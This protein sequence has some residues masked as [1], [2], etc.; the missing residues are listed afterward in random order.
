MGDVV[1]LAVPSVGDGGL[2]AERSGHFGR[3]DC[4]TLVE[5]AD[6]RVS[7]V[8][9]IDNP[10]HM[11]GGCLRPVELLASNGVHALVV[12]GIGARPLAGFEEAGIGVYHDAERPLVREV[13]EAFAAGELERIDPRYVCGGHH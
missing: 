11:E 12:A 13:V 10:P 4:F 2:D 6:G 7:N 8:R 9:V 5:V 3:C 1:V